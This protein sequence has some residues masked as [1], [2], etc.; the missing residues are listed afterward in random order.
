MLTHCFLIHFSFAFFMMFLISVFTFLYLS[1]PSVSPFFFF[2]SLLLSHT[3]RMSEVTYGFF[4]PRCLPRISLAVSV[5]AIIIAVIIVYTS[6]EPVCPRV[7]LIFKIII[8]LLI[9]FLGFIKSKPC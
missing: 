9:I 6:K 8:I 1:L 4:M 2:S 7:E 5:T 3:S